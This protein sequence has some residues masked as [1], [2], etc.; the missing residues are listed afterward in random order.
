MPSDAPTFGANTLTVPGAAPFG[1]AAGAWSDDPPHA[2]SAT[3]S[4]SGAQRLN[5]TAFKRRN[6]NR[7]VVCHTAGSVASAPPGSLS[8]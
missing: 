3:T 7:R 2:A 5:V 4:T 6:L 8:A 1:H